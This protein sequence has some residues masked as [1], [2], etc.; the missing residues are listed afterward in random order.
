M[1]KTKV[2]DKIQKLKAMAKMVGPEAKNAKRLIQKLI[3]KY[4]LNPNETNN[5]KPRQ[6]MRVRT[7]RLKRYALQLAWFIGCPAY[8]YRGEPDFLAIEVD[9]DEY[10]MF[11][12]LYGEIKHIFHK[13]EAELTSLYGRTKTKN[14]ALKSFMAGYMKANYP[15]QHLADRC[16]MCKEGTIVPFPPTDPLYGKSRCDNCGA[17]FGGDMKTHGYGLHGDQYNEGL[18]TTT[19]SLRH[20]KLRLEQK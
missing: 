20:N 1:D 6:R 13:K 14:H 2:L 3:E 11:F 17:L 16:P 12:E 19:K 8:T 9:G 7:H 18:A 5:V 10:L 15:T 4:E